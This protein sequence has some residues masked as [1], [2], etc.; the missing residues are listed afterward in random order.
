MDDFKMLLFYNVFW[1]NACK[2]GK[3]VTERTYQ[4]TRFS[5]MYNVV[6]NET[7][8]WQEEG[9]LKHMKRHFARVK[10]KETT[11]YDTERCRNR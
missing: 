7:T 9:Q 10:A 8:Y 2:T 4:K 5:S 11:I 6:T 1:A 3:I